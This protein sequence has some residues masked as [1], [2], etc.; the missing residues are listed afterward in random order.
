MRKPSEGT[1]NESTEDITTEKLDMHT[2]FM[3]WRLQPTFGKVK[4]KPNAI[5]KLWKEIK[6]EEMTDDVEEDR[7]IK[8]S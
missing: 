4:T 5:E 1:E 8:L 6:E 2:E 3:N 7:L